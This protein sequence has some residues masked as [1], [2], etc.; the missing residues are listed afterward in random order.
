MKQLSKQQL[1]DDIEKLE[2]KFS[3][4]AYL[5]DLETINAWKETVKRSLIADNLKQHEGIKMIIE[6]LDKRI[7][8]IN[9][10]LMNSYSEKISDKTRDRMLDEKKMYMDFLDLFPGDDELKEVEEQVK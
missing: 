2:R 5:E 10:V 9:T 1:L 6:N 7:E 8:E 4:P 3:D